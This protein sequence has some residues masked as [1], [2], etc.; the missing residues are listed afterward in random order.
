MKDKRV[1]HELV[2]LGLAF[3]QNNDIGASLVFLIVANTAR[4]PTQVFVLI[5]TIVLVMS[6][7]LPLRIPTPPV[8]MSTKYSL[9]GMHILGAAVL[10]PLLIAIGVPINSSNKMR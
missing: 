3:L 5:C 1:L 2:N 10:V 8:P 4:R 6:L 9:L 7:F